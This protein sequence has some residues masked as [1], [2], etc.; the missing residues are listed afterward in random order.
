MTNSKPE[1]TSDEITLGLTEGEQTKVT[2][3]IQKLADSLTGDGLE[4]LMNASEYLQ[5][6]SVSNGTEQKLRSDKSFVFPDLFERTADE[7]LQPCPKLKDNK[8]LIK[9]CTDRGKVFRALCVA[10]GIPAVFVDTLDANYLEAIKSAGQIIE[11]KRGHV[12]ID[13][14]VDGEWHTVNPG[15]NEPILQYSNYWSWSRF[16]RLRL[17]QYPRIQKLVAKST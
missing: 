11:P 7:I 16:S 10:K 15:F 17:P 4:F 12:F 1:T 5:R 14:C 2:E 13:V 3:R 6:N 8:P 9:G